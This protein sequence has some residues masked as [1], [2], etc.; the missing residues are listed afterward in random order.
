MLIKFL[1]LDHL[2][3][4]RAWELELQKGENLPRLHV[5]KAGILDDY[6]AATTTT[7]TT[8]TIRTKESYNHAKSN[9]DIDPEGWGMKRTK[10]HFM[11]GRG[12]ESRWTS[13]VRVRLR[14]CKTM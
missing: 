9:A 8:T 1:D 3:K 5:S 2:S 10:E 12:G 6:V 14:Q 7:T 4:G 11:V 13:R